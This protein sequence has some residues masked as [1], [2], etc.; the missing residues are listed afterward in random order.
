MYRVTKNKALKPNPHNSVKWF[1]LVRGL[2]G[3]HLAL[4]S[5]TFRLQRV[6]DNI[7]G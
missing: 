6:G 2:L 7:I 4:D 5:P 3:A 1:N